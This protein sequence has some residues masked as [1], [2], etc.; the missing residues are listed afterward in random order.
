MNP[1]ALGI[2]VVV[3]AACSA[4]ISAVVI[5]GSDQPDASAADQPAAPP[6]PNSR[7]P[8]ASIAGAAPDGKPPHPPTTKFLPRPQPVPVRRH[9]HLAVGPA[10]PGKLTPTD[11]DHVEQDQRKE[12]NTHTSGATARPGHFRP[13][14]VVAFSWNRWSLSLECSDVPRRPEDVDEVVRKLLGGA[15]PRTTMADVS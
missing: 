12:S 4:A 10:T 15:R 13:E 11:H 9:Q 1:L 7:S 3:L 2:I 14:Q 8:P 6:V 5:T